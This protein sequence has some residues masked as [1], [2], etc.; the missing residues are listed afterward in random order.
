MCNHLKLFY[1][2]LIKGLTFAFILWTLHHSE[3]TAFL[4]LVKCSVC[5]GQMSPFIRLLFNWMDWGMMFA[6]PLTALEIPPTRH[7]FLG[8]KLMHSWIAGSANSHLSHSIEQEAIASIVPDY[9]K[10][11]CLNNYNNYNRV[12]GCWSISSVL[13]L[14]RLISTFAASH[15]TLWV[16][17]IF[18]WHK[19]CL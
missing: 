12:Q 4:L 17:V 3:E 14:Q 13:M 5:R 11:Q 18:N 1:F 7:W 10:P 16:F 9:P 2:N 8:W 15:W 19:G 6:S